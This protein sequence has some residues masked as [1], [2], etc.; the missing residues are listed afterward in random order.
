M[1]KKMLK[2]IKGKKLITGVITGLFVF[3]LGVN[4]ALAQY[5]TEWPTYEFQKSLESPSE[6]KEKFDVRTL[7]NV[8]AAIEG[9]LGGKIKPTDR[10]HTDGSPVYER[11]GGAVG[12][13]TNLTGELYNRKPASSVEYI[14]YLKNSINPASRVYAQGIGFSAFSP[15]LE[16]WIVFRNIAYLAFIVVFIIVGFMIMFRKKIDPRTVVTIQSA[17]PKMIVT[18]LLITFSYA[19]AGLVIDV[20]QLTTKLAVNLFAG[21]FIALK[22]TGVWDVPTEEKVNRL[23]NADIFHLVNPLRGTRELFAGFPEITLTFTGDVL[24][25]LSGLTISVVFAI[26]A[27]FV[28]FKIFFSLI[29]PYVSIVLSVIFAPIMLLLGAIPGTQN[30][31]VSWLKGFIANVAVF[32]VTFIML[33]LAAIFKSGKIMCQAYAGWEGM[34]NV[35]ILERADWATRCDPVGTNLWVAPG[36][37]NWGHL[38]GQLISFGI[39]F[40]IPKVAEIVKESLQVKPGLTTQVI[41][42]GIKGGLSKIPVIKDMLPG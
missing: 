35:S 16:L 33:M 10:V 11:S 41:G 9:A 23:L 14:A 24:A 15:V 30:S 6:N 21:K 26:L 36:I 29:G 37:G 1:I 4:F 40:S 28:M 18:L 8:A 22:D 5:E 12:L 27:F 31:F 20:S 13:I 7:G 34:K 17:L 25:F 2:K 3:L 42:E 19:L 32:P 38:V 39:L